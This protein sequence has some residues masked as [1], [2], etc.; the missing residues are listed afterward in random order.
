MASQNVNEND[1]TK[2]L[3]ASYKDPEVKE[4]ISSIVSDVL[5]RHI[6]TLEEKLLT[7]ETRITSLENNLTKVNNE[8]HSLE[9]ELA[10]LLQYTRRNALRIT[11]PAWVEPAEPKDDD[12]D[13]LVLSLAATIRVPLEPWEI[14]RSHRVGQ[15]RTD[16]VP[17][18]ILVKLRWIRLY[19]RAKYRELSWAFLAPPCH[20]F[21][22]GC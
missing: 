1:F 10:Q 4:V 16:G 2:S 7:Q 11:N 6:S 22:T 20:F 18:S 14:G 12:T 17:R 21:R 5:A 9:R 3:I 8:K 13:A 15:P 19:S